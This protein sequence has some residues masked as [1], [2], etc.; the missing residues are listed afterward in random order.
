[1]IITPKDL[2]DNFDEEDLR[3]IEVN[4]YRLGSTEVTILDLAAS[5]AAHVEKIDTDRPKSMMDRTAWGGYDLLA[6][7]SM[8]SSFENCLHAFSG[9]IVSRLMDTIKPFD[10]RFRSITVPDTK[11]LVQSFADEDTSARPWWW[12]R[13][14]DSG[15]ILEEL[16]RQ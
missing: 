5:W 6:A 15:P 10:D 3:Q 1:M 8:R 2:S 13:I 12:H 4:K 7:M 11:G 16:L 9:P 14:P